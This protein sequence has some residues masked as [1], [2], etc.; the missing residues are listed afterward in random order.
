M[1]IVRK[2]IANVLETQMKE[3]RFWLGQIS[4]LNYRGKSLE[5][6]K[7]LPGVYQTFKA[8]ELKDVVARYMKDDRLVRLL[9]IPN[10]Q[11]K[12]TTEP[13]SEKAAQPAGSRM[14]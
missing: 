10:G 14:P 6:V 9:A 2:Q 13:S 4:D 7:A 12:T 5:D 1:G 3:P 11:A 8:D